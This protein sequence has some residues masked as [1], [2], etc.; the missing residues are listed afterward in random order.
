MSLEQAREKALK[1]AK[2]QENSYR[3]IYKDTITWSLKHI[4]DVALVLD[5]SFDNGTELYARHFRNYQAYCS[6][7]PLLSGEQL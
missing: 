7:E 4:I 1:Y 3:N 2:H 6:F 5:D